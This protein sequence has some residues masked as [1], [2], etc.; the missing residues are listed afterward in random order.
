M[1][2][3]FVYLRSSK[4][5]SNTGNV[6]MKVYNETS[7]D[8]LRDEGPWSLVNVNGT[9]GYM[10]SSYLALEAQYSSS[11]TG[12]GTSFQVAPAQP[13]QSTASGSGSCA[14]IA[15]TTCTCVPRWTATS[16][17]TFS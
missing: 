2:S 17:P 10:V 12:S 7:V 5:S 11:T 16:A 8:L 4:D 14:T 9:V 15:A 6:L 1:N 13:A 3:G